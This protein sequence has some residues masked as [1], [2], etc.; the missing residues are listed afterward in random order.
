MAWQKFM[1]LTWIKEGQTTWLKKIIW[2]AFSLLTE[3]HSTFRLFKSSDFSYI[4]TLVFYWSL[5]WTCNCY[6]NRHQK[7]QL[8]VFP[9]LS[10]SHTQTH[11]LL[12]NPKV[13]YFLIKSITKYKKKRWKELKECMLCLEKNFI[14]VI[15][16]T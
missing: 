5:M 1:S 9:Y 14:L 3:K 2:K 10:L 11:F 13:F 6:L 12:F 16:V 8:K 4:H 15:L 7:R